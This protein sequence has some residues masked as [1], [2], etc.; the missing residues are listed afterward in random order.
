MAVFEIKS[1]D[2]THRVL[3]GDFESRFPGWDVSRF[4]DNWKRLRILA[5]SEWAL[6]HQVQLELDELFPDTASIDGLLRWG[7]ILDLPRKGATPSRKAKALRVFGIATTAITLG[8]TLSAANGTQYQVN[9]TETVGAGGFVDVDV[10][11]ISTGSATRLEAGDELDFD[12]PPA[13]ID[14]TAELQID[15]DEGGEDQEDVEAYRVRILDR[16]AQPGMGGNANDYRQWAKEVD[17]VATAYVY[18]LRGGVGSVDLAFLATGSGSVRAPSGASVTEVSD[19]IHSV[20]PVSM[21]DFR[22]LEAVAVEQD[23]EL[24]VRT[25]PGVRWDWD[26]ATPLAVSAWDAGD[27]ILTFATDRPD[28]MEIGDR[29]IIKTDGGDGAESEIVAFD[30]DDGVVLKAAPSTAPVA[31]DVVYAG[32]PVVEPMRQAIKAFVDLLGPAVGEY[33]TGEWDDAIE[34]GR[35]EAIAFTFDET[36]DPTTIEP[37]AAVAPDDPVYPDDDTIE[38]LT[39]GRLIVRR[40]HG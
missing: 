34:P 5:A 33:G 37:A 29:L 7:A 27:R 10:L 31:D 3:I 20:R 8:E 30:G 4:S 21:R 2:A 24:A 38:F 36:R 15:L 17:D 25:R 26:D 16:M 9:E 28:D 12:A 11:A 14:G 22:V 39:Y 23:I 6:H 13:D 18:P 40:D 1:L 35:L 19:Y 32:G